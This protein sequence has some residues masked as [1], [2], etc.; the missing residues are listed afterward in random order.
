MIEIIKPGTKEKI[1]CKSCGCLFSYEK[2]DIEIGHPHNLYH[3]ATEIKYITCP[4]C[5]EKIKLEVT[6]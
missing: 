6:K 2:E 5:N 1:S 4:Q 3:L